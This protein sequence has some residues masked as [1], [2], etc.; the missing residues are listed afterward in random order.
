[1]KGKIVSSAEVAAGARAGISV[2]G[3]D[4][5]PLYIVPSAGELNPAG[6]A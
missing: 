6:S 4:M 5:I 3:W 2:W 1:L